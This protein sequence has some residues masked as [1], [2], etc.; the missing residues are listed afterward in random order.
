LGMAFNAVVA[1]KRAI[2]KAK[3]APGPAAALDRFSLMVAGAAL[4]H[5]TV[6]LINQNFARVMQ[7][8]RARRRTG[9]G[10]QEDSDVEWGKS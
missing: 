8:C 7:L 4:T 3:N 5:E 10:G 2:I 9:R 6:V 1:Q